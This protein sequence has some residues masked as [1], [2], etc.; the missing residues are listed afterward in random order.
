M[1]LD[2]AGCGRGAAHPRLRRSRGPIPFAQSPRGPKPC[3]PARVP[4]S[5]PTV[6]VRERRSP[7]RKCPRH[8]GR[9]FERTPSRGSAAT[10]LD[11]RLL[12]NESLTSLHPADSV[13]PCGVRSG[14]PHGRSLWQHHKLAQKRA[15][16]PRVSYTNALKIEQMPIYELGGSPSLYEED[17]LIPLELGGAPRNPKNLWPEPRRAKAKFF[18]RDGMTCL[19]ERGSRPHRDRSRLAATDRRVAVRSASGNRT[20]SCKGSARAA[21][22]RSLSRV[23]LGA[24][25][26]RG[27]NAQPLRRSYAR[28]EGR[29][30]LQRVRM[31][32]AEDVPKFLCPAY[33]QREFRLS[34][35]HPSRHRGRHHTRFPGILVTPVAEPCGFRAART[36][37]KAHTG[38]EP[39]PPP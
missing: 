2:S 31:R 3:P 35:Q 36:S 5:C 8:Q 9:L 29:S 11:R 19:M 7:R 15:C 23:Y 10:G 20:P 26:P 1:R 14:T 16:L 33:W 13:R 34:G 30:N 39:V 6:R 24:A 12:R 22:G 37:R 32:R 4:S 25:G 27:E 28:N 18:R 21:Q 38:F 17:H